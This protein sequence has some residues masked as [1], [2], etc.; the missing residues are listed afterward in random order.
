MGRVVTKHPLQDIHYVGRSG[1]PNNITAITIIV[2]LHLASYLSRGP[3]CMQFLMN[4]TPPF[5]YL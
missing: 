2:A 1:V 5:A 4:S 3:N